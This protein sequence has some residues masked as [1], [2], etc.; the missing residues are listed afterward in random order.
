MLMGCNANKSGHHLKKLSLNGI[1]MAVPSEWT[2]KQEQGIELT[3]QYFLSQ[4]SD[5]IR[6]NING[7]GNEFN[8]MI[9]VHS[10]EEKQQ[11]DKINWEYIDEMIFSEKADLEEAQGLYLNEYFFYDTIGGK[12]AKI[13]MPKK[14]GK[15]AMGIYF[16]DLNGKSFSIYAHD[17]D[18]LNHFALYNVFQSIR[19]Q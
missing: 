1:S 2:L 15:G 8:K 3:D 6:L 9:N 10:M 13:M 11:F 4:D 14:I 5:T 12:A 7:S 16:E 18:T 19:L 17:L